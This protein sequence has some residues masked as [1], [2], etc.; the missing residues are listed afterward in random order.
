[1]IG[2]TVFQVKRRGAKYQPEV[3]EQRYK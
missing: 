3:S 1:M 2:E